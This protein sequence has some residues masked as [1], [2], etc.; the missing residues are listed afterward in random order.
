MVTR[1]KMKDQKKRAGAARWHKGRSDIEVD[2]GVEDGQGIPSII[3]RARATVIF[4][5]DWQWEGF[6]W[7]RQERPATGY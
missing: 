4:E 6:K 3:Y 5:H 7:H 2:V 1:T